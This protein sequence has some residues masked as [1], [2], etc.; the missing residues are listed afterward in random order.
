MLL[1]ESYLV[2]ECA[3]KEFTVYVIW[4]FI[5]IVHHTIIWIIK[6]LLKYYFR[7]VKSLSITRFTALTTGST[8]LSLKTWSDIILYHYSLDL[9]TLS[10][11]R[12]EILMRVIPNDQ[13][14]KAFKEYEKEKKPITALSEEDRFMITVSW[15][16]ILCFTQV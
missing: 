11:E 6:M 10:L 7:Y 1:G 8:G 15:L 3:S 9:K 14:V 5:N 12:V 2:L 16:L 13:E 4:T